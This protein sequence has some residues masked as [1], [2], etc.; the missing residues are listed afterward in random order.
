MSGLFVLFSFNTLNLWPRRINFFTVHYFICTN[1]Y[2]ILF[3]CFKLFNSSLCRFLLF[4]CYGFLVLLEFLIGCNLNLIAL[5]TAYLFPSNWNCFLCRFNL[6]RI[7]WFR[8]CNTN[9]L[10]SCIIFNWLLLS[11]LLCNLLWCFLYRL[12]WRLW[13]RVRCRSRFRCW[14]WCWFRCRC[15]TC[16]L[17]TSPSPRD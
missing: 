3:L 9:L 15:W 4:N 12:S 13:C 17:Y 14:S 11:S 6:F 5:Y 16:L 1:S 2:I 8:L 7:S 10:G